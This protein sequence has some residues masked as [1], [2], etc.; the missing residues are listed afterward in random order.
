MV[1][2]T[3]YIHT[4]LWDGV[5]QPRPN[6]KDNLAKQTLGLGNEYVSDIYKLL[7]IHPCLNLS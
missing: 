5:T 4:K 1:C 2:I 6:F 7:F 3:T